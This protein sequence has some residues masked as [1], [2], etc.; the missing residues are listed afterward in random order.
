MAGSF[1]FV[2]PH[3]TVDNGIVNRQDEIVPKQEYPVSQ[4]KLDAEW[5]K[6]RAKI[7]ALH[8]KD[9]S[10]RQIANVLELSTQRVYVV[11]KEAGITFK[12]RGSK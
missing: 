7:L 11:L 1:R 5:A 3:N 8:N 9:K 6:R 2:R 12:P 10:V 4:A